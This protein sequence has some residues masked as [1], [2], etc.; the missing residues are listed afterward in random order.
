MSSARMKT[1]LGVRGASTVRADESAARTTRNET[2][3]RNFMG[4][5]SRPFLEP[6]MHFSKRTKDRLMIAAESR[7]SSYGHPERSAARAVVEEMRLGACGRRAVEGALTS[8][9]G[10]PAG[11][12][13]REVPSVSSGQALR[14][15]AARHTPHA[16]PPFFPHLHRK[17]RGAPLRMTGFWKDAPGGLQRHDTLQSF[18][19]FARF[20][21]ADAERARPLSHSSLVI[22]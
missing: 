11:R 2:A 17:P 4:G 19:I 22:P 18:V 21:A 3:R 5:T 20:V 13:K 9:A 12:K 10:G 14:L 1:M 15:R 7:P 16:P 8:S 6:V